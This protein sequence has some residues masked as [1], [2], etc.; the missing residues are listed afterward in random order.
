MYK[1]F[2]TNE[3]RRQFVLAQTHANEPEPEFI[4][5]IYNYFVGFVN[6]GTPE[7]PYGL[8]YGVASWVPAYRTYAKDLHGLVH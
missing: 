7:T 5:P 6:G 4:G 8:S 1:L 2:A 3:E